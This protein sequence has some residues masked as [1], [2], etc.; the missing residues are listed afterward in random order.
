MIGA[1]KYVENAWVRL[2]TNR[3][4]VLSLHIG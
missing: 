2:D 4:D 1:L 3:Y